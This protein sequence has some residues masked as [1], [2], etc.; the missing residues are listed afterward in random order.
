MLTRG[1]EKERSET[2]VENERPS[3]G[4]RQKFEGQ[5]G[6]FPGPSRENTVETQDPGKQRKNERR[7]LC[8]WKCREP[9][10]GTLRTHMPWD[11]GSLYGAVLLTLRNIALNP[12]DKETKE[13]GREMK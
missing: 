5:N 9:L 2:S 4:G 6:E 13:K 7:A 8:A 10:K 11:C 3:R 12:I 1:V